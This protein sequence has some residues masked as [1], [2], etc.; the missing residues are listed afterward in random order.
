MQLNL[1]C[2]EAENRFFKRLTGI[3]DPEE[4]RK[5]IGNEF[6]KIFEEKSVKFKGVEFLAQ[7]TFYPDVIESTSFWEA[8]SVKIK[9]HHNV[10]RIAAE[11]EA[12][13]HRT[14]ERAF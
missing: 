8:H 2:V 10:G 5:I 1:D 6:V 11:Y 12:K 13:A 9:T 7:G 14:P 3:I 4:K